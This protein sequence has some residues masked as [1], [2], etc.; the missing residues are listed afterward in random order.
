VWVEGA[1]VVFGRA[2]LVTVGGGGWVVSEE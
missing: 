1:A 2:E